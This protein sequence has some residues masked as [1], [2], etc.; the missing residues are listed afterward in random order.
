VPRVF[1]AGRE[2]GPDSKHTMLNERW[3]S[4]P[5]PAKKGAAR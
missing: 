2:V 1:I 4:R 3:S 5:L